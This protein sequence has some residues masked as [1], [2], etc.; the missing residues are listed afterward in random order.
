M[1]HFGD[2]VDNGDYACMGAG[3]I[4]EMPMLSS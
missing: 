2:E 4:Q 1:C 3:D